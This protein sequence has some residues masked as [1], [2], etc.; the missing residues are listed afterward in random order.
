M[1]VTESHPDSS[2]PDPSQSDVSAQGTGHEHD[3]ARDSSDVVSGDRA[4]R[5]EA[6]KNQ[7]HAVHD[8]SKSAGIVSRGVGAVIDLIVV[9]VIMSAIYLGVV[10]ARLLYNV[11]DFSMPSTNGFFTI[12]AFIV[13]SIVYLASCWAVSG[14]TLGSVVMG[15]RVVNRKGNRL[16]PTIA[17]LR[18]VICV[19]F[20]IGLL[21]VGV[22]SRRR[23]VADVLLRTRVVYSR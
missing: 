20:A 17:V 14:R 5:R 13:V 23:S 10:M 9:L 2:L 21:W 7:F 6:R 19:F 4:A 1:S 18:S 15:I 16:R 12:G 3:G 8:T 11:H 22:D